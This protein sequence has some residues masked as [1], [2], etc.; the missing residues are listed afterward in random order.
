MATE[1]MTIYWGSGT[2]LSLEPIVNRAK[3]HL[4]GCTTYALPIPK[5][6]GLRVHSN[7]LKT[8]PSDPCPGR[9]PVT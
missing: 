4:T 1:L 3:G 7:Q 8:S 6:W 9:W 2:L 5:R